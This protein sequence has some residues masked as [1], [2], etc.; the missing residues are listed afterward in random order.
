MAYK[1]DNFYFAMFYFDIF[2]LIIQLILISL[3]KGMVWEI[4]TVV[5]QATKEHQLKILEQERKEAESQDSEEEEK[6]EKQE[7][8]HD[9]QNCK[10]GYL[11][12]VVE[13]Q[14]SNF[15]LKQNYRLKSISQKLHLS[16]QYNDILLHLVTDEN[17]S[18][19]VNE[20]PI[21]V[22]NQEDQTSRLKYNSLLLFPS[23]CTFSQNHNHHRRGSG[24]SNIVIKNV[25]NTPQE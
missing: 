1:F 12:P 13:R 7:N 10:H 15:A 20:S 4:F 9:S 2:H 11:A 19:I 22:A 23:R 24:S 16:T 6:D 5:E 14:D 17:K 3:V 8:S 18:A 25:S 21:Q